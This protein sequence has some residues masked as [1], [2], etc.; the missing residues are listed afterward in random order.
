MSYIAETIGSVKNQ[1]YTNWEMIIVDDCSTDESP[2]I[3]AEM[4]ASDDRIKYYKNDKQSG[5]SQTRNAAICM[6]KG[7]YIAF[8]DSDDLWEPDKLR[9]QIEFMQANNA[10]FCCG[11]CQII[12]EHGKATG[13]VRHVP[14]KCDYK[15]LLKGNIAACLTVVIDRKHIT[16]I[17]MPQMPHEDYATWLNIAKDG[18]IIYGID[19]VM[20]SYRV[21]GDSVSSNKIKAAAWTW[22]IYRNYLEMSFIK[23]LFYFGCYIF[24][25][26]AK[27]I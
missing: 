21:A 14:D 25:A 4:A 12:D 24:N 7:R 13:K 3:V 5:V 9:I 20:A 23:S 1:T 15:K 17:K 16:D 18:E 11:A 26:V 8:L 2:Q 22:R 10:H 6:A 27:R 19:T